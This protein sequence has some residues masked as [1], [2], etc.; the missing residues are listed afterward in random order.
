MVLDKMG[1]LRRTDYCGELTADRV[2]DEIT[3]AGSIAKSRD[4]G[5]VIFADLRDT[6]GIL[7]LAFDDSTPKEVFEKASLLRSEYVV[8]ARG[9]LRRRESVN[10]ALPTARL[11]CMSPNCGSS[12]GRRPPRLRSETRSRSRTTCV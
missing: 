4:L 6:T 3:V 10:R 9:T 7:Q 12:A 8:I 11:S 2:G 5:G 1:D